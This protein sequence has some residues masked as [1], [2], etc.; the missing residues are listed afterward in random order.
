MYLASGHVLYR[1]NRR[2]RMFIDC[3][4][5][6]K[7]LKAEKRGVSSLASQKG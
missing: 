2:V 6:E 4:K 1:R 5:F 3:S 7:V